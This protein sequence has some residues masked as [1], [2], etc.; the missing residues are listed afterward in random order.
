MLSFFR[1]PFRI[2]AAILFIPALASAQNA[3]APKPPAAKPASAAPPVSKNPK[4]WA[5]RF[6]KIAAAKSMD[7][8]TQADFDGLDADA[9]Y[10]IYRETFPQIK[11]EAVRRGVFRIVLAKTKDPTVIEREPARLLSV[12]DISLQGYQ[13]DLGADHAAIHF[14]AAAALVRDAEGVA[15]LAQSKWR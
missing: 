9:A 6:G 5:A 3:A 12:L 2:V 1:V 15:G 14:A 4:E 8:K 13:R 11:N 7:A 10:Q